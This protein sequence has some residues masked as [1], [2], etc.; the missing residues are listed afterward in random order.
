MTFLA[1]LTDGTRVCGEVRVAAA[2]RAGLAVLPDGSHV[3]ALGY[4][5][6]EDSSTTLSFK[7]PDGSTALAVNTGASAC[8]CG[9]ELGVACNVR[10]PAKVQMLADTSAGPGRVKSSIGIT[11]SPAHR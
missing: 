2:R 3:M 1:T 6:V 5:G 8:D 10:D 7:V 4:V 11:V 9:S